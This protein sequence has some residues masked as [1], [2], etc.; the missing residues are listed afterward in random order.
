MNT[1]SDRLH[2]AV[3]EAT[4]TPMELE[5][6]QNPA[7]ILLDKAK[8][9]AFYE[10]IKREVEA[11]VPD[12]STETGRKSIASLAYKV[13]RTKTAIDDAGKELNAKYRE[14]INMVDA[15]RRAIREKFDA[16]KD[17][18]RRPLTEWEKK[19]EAR[20][21]S[22]Q[23]ILNELRNSAVIPSGVGLEAVI[24]RLA[25]I[26]ATRIDSAVFIEMADV[27]ISA[28]T[29]AINAHQAAIQRLRQEEA[30]R[31]ELAR[32]RA[33]KEAREAADREAARVAEQQRLEA[34]AAERARREQERRAAEEAA[35]IAKAAQEAEARAK[36]E[37][38][39]AARKEQ[40]C[41]ERAHQAALESERRERAV[42][43]QEAAK[44]H[45]DEVRRLQQE[46]DRLEAERV[47]AAQ[48]EARRAAEAAQKEAEERKLAAN[49]KRR[50]AIMTT[51]KVALMEH[52]G[53]EEESARKAVLA[54]STDKV[55][56]VSI[57]FA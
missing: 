45:Q 21:A 32:L 8:Q 34:E 12:T 52:A 28:K 40:E 42:A 19:E 38:E 37:A 46:R 51:A 23:A 56:A 3:A 18:A 24:D 36:R 43:E 25:E 26:E 2:E 27:A 44:K 39:E 48:Q 55:P 22:C 20:I 33:E 15:S 11:F 49:K 10:H 4:L 50:A 41:I 9:D 31:V 16:L 1:L 54:I 47:K 5:V 29:V 14:Q 53:L 30:D 35:R 57:R 6:R 13:A 7:V 17:Q